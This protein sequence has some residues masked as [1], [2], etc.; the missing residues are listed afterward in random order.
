MPFKDSNVA[1]QYW[2]DYALK[3]SKEIKIRRHNYYLSHREQFKGYAK[4]GKN[5]REQHN[6]NDHMKRRMKIIELLGGQCANLYFLHDKPFTDVR[7][8]QIDHINGGG[9]EERRQFDYME[10]YYKYV[11]EQGPSRFE[12]LSVALCK[13]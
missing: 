10:K 3:Y 6:K 4:K 9:N 12:G 7:C 13:L 5:K 11:L 1:K 8:L 2:K